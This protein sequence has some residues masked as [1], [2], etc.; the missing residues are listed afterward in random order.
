MVINAQ[1][2][3]GLE[4]DIAVLADIDRHKPKQ[5]L[6]TLKSRFYVMVARGR[7]WSYCCAPEPV[8]R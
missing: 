5:D 3:K 2:C 8:V 6:H 1:S 4:F 7:V